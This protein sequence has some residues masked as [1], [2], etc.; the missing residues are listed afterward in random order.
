MAK[1]IEQGDFIRLDFT[2]R[3]SSGKVFETTRAQDAKENGSFDARVKYAPALVVAGK[4]QLLKGLDDAV[5]K[6]TEGAEQNVALPKE[7]AFGERDPALVRLVTLTH[8]RQSGIEPVAGQ[9]VELD[10]RPARVQSVN[11]GRVR[12]D[13]NSEL[14]GQNLAYSFKVTSVMKTA[15]EKIAGLA[16]DLNAKA[17]LANQVVTVKVDE[18]VPKDGRFL[19]RKLRFLQHALLYIQEVEKV[20]FQE[21]YARPKESK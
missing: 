2:G 12:V 9:V 3:D 20:V 13:F 18:T 19:E 16:E 17:T 4:G 15:E 14:A 5:L 11:G 10:G 8:F 21:E 1:S 7:K 6:T